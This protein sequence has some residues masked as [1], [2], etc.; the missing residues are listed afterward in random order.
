MF[1]Y[2]AADYKAFSEEEKARYEA[3]YCGLC[4]RLDVGFGSVGCASLTYDMTFL[5]ILLG[6][7][8][9]L[10]EGSGGRRCA[11]HPIK[12][13]PYVETAATAYAADMNILLAYYQ[14]LDDWHDDH[15]QMARKKSEMLKPFLPAIRERNPRQCEVVEG[16]LT[17]LGEMERANELNPDLPAN[18][19]GELMAE[20]FLWHE[21]EYQKPL[22]DM[23]AALGRFIYLLDAVNDLRA[24][25]KKQRY[26]PLVG[27]LDTDYTPLLT[28]MMAECTEA[29]AL[30]PLERDLHILQ[31]VLYSGVWQ[32][33][34]R[35]KN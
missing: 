31:N 7:L 28:L 16:K 21:D 8:Y 18:C 15:N 24:D 22:H 20:L 2:I 19:F 14:A 13:R 34:H 12:P 26:N 17:T 33:Y 5:S 23:G 30:L 10:L 25:I 4:H 6:S 29:F 3:H 1:G 27:Q 32:R 35:R 9:H 11:S